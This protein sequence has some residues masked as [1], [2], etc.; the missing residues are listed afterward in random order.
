[1]FIV[2]ELTI[3]IN[4]LLFITLFNWMN[5]DGIHDTW[6]IVNIFFNFYCD[7]FNNSF[8][9]FCTLYSTF[10]Q[11]FR[12]KSYFCQRTHY[13][14]HDMIHDISLYL[15]E[16]QKTFKKIWNSSIYNVKQ[17]KQIMIPRSF[18]LCTCN[19]IHANHTKKKR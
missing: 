16:Q 19:K 3:W 11:I 15:N 4:Y 6:S 14:L 5:G 9:S 8:Q 12:I 13:K 10:V 2:E 7:I 17:G 1:M 18:S